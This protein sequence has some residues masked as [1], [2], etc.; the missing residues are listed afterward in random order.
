MVAA[1]VL[2][3]G[4][5]VSWLDVPT[6]LAQ[7]GDELE[8]EVGEGVNIQDNPYLYWKCWRTDS[9]LGWGFTAKDFKLPLAKG[10]SFAT[11]Y[12][13][14]LTDGRV[15]SRGFRLTDVKAE[16]WKRTRA[17]LIDARFYRST[18]LLGRASAADPSGLT[19]LADAEQEHLFKA[20]PDRLLPQWNPFL[21]EGDARIK[22]IDVQWSTGAGKTGESHQDDVDRLQQEQGSSATVAEQ[23]VSRAV[24]YRGDSEPVA[25][26]LSEYANLNEDPSLGGQ[27]AL[28]A[29]IIYGTETAQVV[30][31]SG[32]VTTSGSGGGVTTTV[33]L[34]STSRDVT[35]N[36]STTHR[37]DPTNPEVFTTTVSKSEDHPRLYV[38][39]SSGWRDDGAGS[40]SVAT[41]RNIALRPQGDTPMPDGAQLAKK[42]DPASSLHDWAESCFVMG[43]DRVPDALGWPAN[44][45]YR[46]YRFLCWL[47]RDSSVESPLEPQPVQTLEAPVVRIGAVNA[48]GQTILNIVFGNGRTIARMPSGGVIQVDDVP[49]WI[50]SDLTETSDALYFESASRRRGTLAPPEI[51]DEPNDE[52][53]VSV[54][55]KDGN[56]RDPTTP[57]DFLDDSGATSRTWKLFGNEMVGRRTIV[58]GEDILHGGYKQ[59]YMLPPFWGGQGEA[60]RVVPWMYDHDEELMGVYGMESFVLW[61]V[62][63]A[64]MNYYLFKVDGFT[65]EH[66]GDRG[67]I[68]NLA[69]AGV[70]GI[71]PS[72]KSVMFMP[73]VTMAVNI[74][75]NYRG[76]TGVA[77]GVPAEVKGTS[78]RTAIGLNNQ[79]SLTSMHINPFTPGK[80]YYPFYDVDQYSDSTYWANYNLDSP[81]RFDTS[82][83][84]K[85][86]VVSPDD[87]GGSDNQYG[88]NSRFQWVIREGEAVAG[89]EEGNV[90]SV[91][92][93]LGIDPGY[94]S[95]LDIDED[96]RHRMNPFEIREDG[97]SAASAWPNSYISPDETHVLLLTFYEGRDGRMWKFVPKFAADV[98]LGT[99]TYDATGKIASAF[100]ADGA[101]VLGGLLNMVG[102]EQVGENLNTFAKELSGAGALGSHGG[103][104]TFQYRRVLCRVVVPPDGVVTPGTG[105]TAVVDSLEVAKDFIVEGIKNA[106]GGLIGWLE[107]FPGK[108]MTGM[109]ATASEGACHGGGI[110]S[111]VGDGENDVGS[112]TDPTTGRA[113]LVI[114]ET[115]HTDRLSKR[116]SKKVEIGVEIQR[117]DK[118]VGRNLGV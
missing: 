47:V 97:A 8:L 24:A 70:S 26:H 45:P 35:N 68:L 83:L 90:E 118:G 60:D 98:P 62:Y 107:S 93:R 43:V 64:D 78:G 38:V 34:E 48:I 21:S 16:R 13:P 51:G 92:R 82:D 96:E 71:E 37:V 58:H 3:V 15:D 10:L 85:A 46:E 115:E 41:V 17:D 76:K 29:R 91:Y 39:A 22:D 89:L 49:I 74:Y 25:G 81:T 104:P 32:T 4:L 6:A 30:D 79:H 72:T 54:N 101:E 66:A 28:G 100:A 52:I 113:D 40:H 33:D 11:P 7:D 86:G 116:A 108:F 110:L 59:S 2:S 65:K 53:V 103:V 23:G 27:N 18:S 87:A 31:L 114:D 88:A 63:L 1:V 19:P 77:V 55:L 75:N 99:A 112:G 44:F 20:D 109:M 94:L 95:N 36:V 111:D 73:A 105:L 14:Q 80:L 106:I 84:L 69:Y 117:H 56:R 42:V 9:K 5:M 57:Y 102:A 50:E 61:P 12:L 67:H